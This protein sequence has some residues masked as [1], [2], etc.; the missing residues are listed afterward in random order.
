MS[1]N[2]R[3]FYRIRSSVGDCRYSSFTHLF[4]WGRRRERFDLSQL[5]VEIHCETARLRIISNDLDKSDKKYDEAVD[6][7]K[8]RFDFEEG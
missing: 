5:N 3:T 4:N 8:E 2:I 6:D 1:G 7:L